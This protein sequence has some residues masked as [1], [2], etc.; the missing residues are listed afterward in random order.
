[1]YAFTKLTISLLKKRKLLEHQIDKVKMD[2]RM[3]DVGRSSQSSIDNLASEMVPMASMVEVV[4]NMPL[5][6]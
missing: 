2:K 6:S 5:S 1:M 3:I 4:R